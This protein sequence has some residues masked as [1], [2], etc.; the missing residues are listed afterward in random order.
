[1][2]H[3]R[4]QFIRRA[5][6]VGLSSAGLA[7]TAGCDSGLPSGLGRKTTRVPRIG[8]LGLGAQPVE[9]SPSIGA[10]RLGLRDLGYI[11]GQTIL[12]EWRYA[13]DAEQLPSLAG[14]LVHLQ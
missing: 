9:G 7:L 8:Y 10:F 11:E 4:R 2:H 3:S 5:C 12:I 1:M 14:D 6:A 13:D